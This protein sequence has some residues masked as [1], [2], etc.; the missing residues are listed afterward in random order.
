[1][2]KSRGTKTVVVVDGATA[3][4]NSRLREIENWAR[5]R[6]DERN[7]DVSWGS[8]KR[9]TSKSDD[10]E[11]GDDASSQ[12]TRIKTVLKKVCGAMNR[13]APDTV[14]QCADAMNEALSSDYKQCDNSRKERLP[15]HDEDLQKESLSEPEPNAVAAAAAVY[16]TKRVW[17]EPRYAVVFARIVKLVTCAVFKKTLLVTAVTQS[18]VNVADERVNGA[19]V[20]FAAICNENVFGDDD[21]GQR[22]IRATLLELIHNAKVETSGDEGGNCP[23][24][25]AVHN[26]A[27]RS[28]CVFAE[29]GAV[30]KFPDLNERV[31]LVLVNATARFT[32][33]QSAFAAERAL[34]VFE[35]S[36]AVGDCEAGSKTN[37][38]AFGDCVGSKPT[39]GFFSYGRGQSLSR[40]ETHREAV[41][42]FSRNAKVGAISKTANKLHIVNAGTAQ[43]VERGMLQGWVFQYIG[44]GANARSVEASRL[45]SAEASRL[46]SADASEL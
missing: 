39:R 34:R 7:Y 45:K 42:D 41:I 46:K 14:V 20:F 5:D 28:L 9:E 35:T 23:T 12:Q 27:L 11:D 1:M 40:L 43:A 36:C 19:S 21:E 26:K 31:R 24:S 22:M 16:F 6:D 3:P 37:G 18:F 13:A 29:T 4:V 17:R 32:G 15:E 10:D 8:S 30:V 2:S 44:G 38:N 33:T 25:N